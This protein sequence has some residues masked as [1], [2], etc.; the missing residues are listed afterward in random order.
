[1]EMLVEAG[2]ALSSDLSL[3]VVLRRIVELATQVTSARYGAVG[4]LGPDGRI[5]EF[6]TIGID[7]EVRRAIG[8]YPTGGGILGA[9]IDDATPL[10]LDDIS[11]DPRSVGFPPNHPPMTSFLGAPV[12]ALG[13]VYGNIY[14]TEK[15][16]GG[17]F[18]AEDEEDLV[19][20]A[21]QAGVAVANA[22]LYAETSRRE[23]WLDAVAET[24][25]A[26]LAG[27]EARD[28]LHLVAAR[29]RE[30]AGADLATIATPD[31]DSPDD[32]LVVVATDGLLADRLLGFRL[33]MEGTISGDVIR[34]GTP[35]VLADT[36]A[37]PRA[38]H[39][40]SPMGE[41]GPAI[42]VPLRERAEAYGTLVVA[43]RRGGPPFVDDDVRL[44]VSFADQ[45][46]VALEYSRT[47]EDLRRLVVMEDRER[48]AKELHDGVIQSLFAVGMGLQATA[49]L[50]GDEQLTSRIE[51]AVS[52]L[53]RAIRDLR[54]YIFGLRP[55]IL[56]DRQ[57]DQALRELAEDFGAK[58][59]VTIV[60]DVDEHV[61]AELSSQAG[62]IVQLTR[63]ALSNVG[64]HA[65][66]ATCRVSLKRN[67][68]HAVL[69]VDDDGLGFD[70]ASARGTGSGLRNLAARAAALGGTLQIDSVEGE[71]T[72]IRV[73]L[74]R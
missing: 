36:S 71:G 63:E 56:A 47:R 37:D 45:A 20:L 28:L 74:T 46:A 16:G 49:M 26:I 21:T 9:L 70:V 18:T 27:S 14:L 1:M 61:A 38:H 29:A 66:A 59:G 15:H 41:T 43:N 8:A 50:A 19:V 65:G 69:E 51:G 42:F 7:D 34:S 22:H 24:T 23:R 5:Q 73:V 54:N 2:L 62:D 4:V 10:R 52:E 35:L 40:E 48:I 11:K 13:R 31:H 39:P 32:P 44:V 72:T 67:G 58:G 6:V 53:D 64:R 30:L 25:A 68:A 3:P 55:G 33:P 60:V 57:L 17:A 12:T